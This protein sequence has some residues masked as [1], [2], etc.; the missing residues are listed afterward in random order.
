MLT[1]LFFL[2]P[3]YFLISNIFCIYKIKHVQAWYFINLCPKHYT[4][5][6]T[7]RN[8]YNLIL[9][10][11]GDTHQSQTNPKSIRNHFVNVSGVILCGFNFV[12]CLCFFR[13]LFHRVSLLLLL[14]I[15]FRYMHKIIICSMWVSIS[16][17]SQYPLSCQARKGDR[18]WS[19]SWV[20]KKCL[21]NLCS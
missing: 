11:E 15:I 4:I 8:L 18:G 13:M 6:F 7:K 19:L 20:I 5:R 17:P 1:N 9:S 14:C 2:Q 16:S 21:M 3:L 12:V 10:A